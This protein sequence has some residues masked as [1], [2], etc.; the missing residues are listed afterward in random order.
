MHKFSRKDGT[1]G[2]IEWSKD[3]SAVN[4]CQP[5]CLT[6][7]EEWCVTKAHTPCLHLKYS[8]RKHRRETEQRRH[9]GDYYYYETGVL[10]SACLCLLRTL[11]VPLVKRVVQSLLLSDEY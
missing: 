9:G 2:I 11:G 5:P 3:G 8:H 7:S 6:F 4:A 1:E 10:A